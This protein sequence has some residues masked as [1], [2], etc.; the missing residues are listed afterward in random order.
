MEINTSNCFS[1]RKKELESVSKWK[2]VTIKK[3]KC[4]IKVQ[5]SRNVLFHFGSMEELVNVLYRCRK[6]Q[7]NY[8]T[9]W[10]ELDK[11]FLK[12]QF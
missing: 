3:M 10:N 1:I 5:V 2:V 12:I 4:L 6:G 7:S 8:E 9:F 11:M